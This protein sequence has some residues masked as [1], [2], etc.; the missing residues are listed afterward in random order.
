MER[1]WYIICTK[2]K[3]EKKVLAEL[4]KKGIDCCCPFTNKEMKYGTKTTI[5]YQPV[6]SSYVFAFISATEIHA[7]KRKPSVVN[8]AHW[9]SKP[10]IMSEEEIE[11][12]RLMGGSYINIKLEKS[13]VNI[14]EKVSY[15]VDSIT[16][17]SNEFVS[18]KPRRLKIVLPTLGYT[19]MA[20][21]AHAN[22]NADVPRKRFSL[23]SL[24]PKKLKLAYSPGL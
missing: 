2:T 7:I 9:Q 14:G 15:I 21:R 10:V 24:F 16:S 8:L 11:A 4:A 17:Y 5:E 20:E 3:Q 13:N 19:M 22:A 18:I 1:N 23:G 6:F 12:I